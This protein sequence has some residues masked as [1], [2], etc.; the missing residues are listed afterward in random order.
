MTRTDAAAR[1][2]YAWEDRVVAPRDSSRVTREHM[3]ALVDHV[4]QAE[5]LRWPPRI[6]PLPGQARGT[7]A[8]ATRTAIEVPEALPSWVLLHEMAHAM[9]MDV[10][11]AGAGHGAAFVGVYLRLLVEHARMERAPLE[12]TLRDQGV[13]FDAAARP[14]VGR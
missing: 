13:A 9:T 2:L 1:R 10:E 12:A 7:V 14:S 3:Q 11:G 5:G 6:R 4:W 8:R